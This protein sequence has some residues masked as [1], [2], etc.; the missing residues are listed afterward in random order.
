[1]KVPN[2]RGLQ[3]I[4]IDH[5]SDIGFK[6]FSENILQNPDSR[7]QIPEPR[8]LFVHTTPPSDSALHF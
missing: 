7:F 5:S 4:A 3:Q 8:F 1:M 2:R 6:G